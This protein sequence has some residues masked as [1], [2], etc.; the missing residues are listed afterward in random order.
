MKKKELSQRQLAEILRVSPQAVGKATAKKALFRNKVGL[1]D[2]SH[3]VNR[4]YLL[5]RGLAPSRVR[6]PRPGVPGRPVKSTASARGSVTVTTPAGRDVDKSELKK[7][8]VARQ[9]LLLQEQVKVIFEGHVPVSACRLYLDLYSK[10]TAEEYETF[11]GEASAA[12]QAHFGIKLDDDKGAALAAAIRRE[13]DSVLQAKRTAIEKFLRSLKRRNVE[14]PAAPGARK[15]PRHIVDLVADG[16]LTLARL[17]ALPTKSDV[18]KVKIALEIQ[19][20]EK[21]TQIARGEWITLARWKR[22]H[23]EALRA[24]DGRL[25]SIPW[26]VGVDLAEVFGEPARDETVMFHAR[27][28]VWEMSYKPPCRVWQR[29]NDFRQEKGKNG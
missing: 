16:G 29:M 15:I 23:G 11:I 18:E 24:L 8:K 20:I 19:R 10:F 28:V 25:Y 2:L 5:E 6:I 4:A 26:R 7:E 17:M 27:N 13:T 9:C 3:P 12:L 14:A 21:Q 22:F 1:Y